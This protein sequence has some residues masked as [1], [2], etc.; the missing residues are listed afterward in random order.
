VGAGGDAFVCWE[1][2]EVFFS[3]NFAK[4][5]VVE[6]E[7]LLFVV[8]VG[9]PE[10][11]KDLGFAGDFN[12]LIF[13]DIIENIRIHSNFSQFGCPDFQL[14]QYLGGIKYDLKTS[15]IMTLV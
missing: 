7:V 15:E 11:L 6:A 14:C 1:E 4:E 5:G 9:L 10:E 8:S 13:S 3:D 2:H 12:H